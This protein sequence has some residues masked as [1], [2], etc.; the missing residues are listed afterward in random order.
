MQM[1]FHVADPNND[2]RLPSVNSQHR[3]QAMISTSR[4]MQMVLVYSNAYMDYR[5]SA[6]AMRTIESRHVIYSH[7]RVLLSEYSHFY[8]YSQLKTVVYRNVTDFGTHYAF[9]N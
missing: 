1:E 8:N 9:T 5:R 2:E 3:S 6:P 7:S 4:Y